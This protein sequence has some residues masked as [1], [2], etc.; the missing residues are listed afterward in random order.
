MSSVVSYANNERQCFCQ[1]RLDSGE[2]VL[3]SIAGRPTP[4]LKVIRMMLGGL[5]PGKTIWEYN[6]TQAGGLEAYAR[7]LVQ[8][9][10]RDPKGPVHPLDIIRDALLR[11]SSI[12]NARR[13]LSERQ[14]SITRSGSEETAR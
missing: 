7:G 10:P 2:R 4:S 3:I 12:E 14:A 6:A 9:F 5:I 1:I 8:M 13:T 11:C